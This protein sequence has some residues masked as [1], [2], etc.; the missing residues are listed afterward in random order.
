[1]IQLNNLLFV[2]LEKNEV[3]CKNVQKMK[4]IIRNKINGTENCPS[5]LS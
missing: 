1:M 5:N 2:D 4:I 3:G